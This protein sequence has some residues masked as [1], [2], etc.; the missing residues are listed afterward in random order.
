MYS[1]ERSSLPGQPATDFK[2]SSSLLEQL[3]AYSGSDFYPFHMPGHKRTP[4]PFPNP[5]TVDITEIEGFD[6]LHRPEGILKELQEETAR[7][8]GARQSFLLVNGS[9]CGLLAAVSA[10]VKRGGKLL[11]SRNCHKSVYHAVYLRDLTPVYLLPKLTDFGVMGSLEPEE[12]ER[13]LRAQPDIQAVLAV[14]PTYDGVVSDIERIAAITHRH[15]VPLIVDEAHGA[16]FPFGEE[17]L[18]PTSAL[19]LGADLVVQSLHKTLPAFT[20]TA[21]LHLNTELVEEAVLKRFLGI[22]QS[23]SPSY[24]LM[25]SMAQCMELLKK[26]GPRRFVDF[27]K[28]LSRF[29]QSCRRLS[30]I[31]LFDGHTEAHCFAWDRSKLLIS[32]SELGLSGQ[33]L[34]QILLREY[35]LQMEMASGHYVLALTSLMDREEGFAR[36]AEALFQIERDYGAETAGA[37]RHT[38]PDAAPAPFTPLHSGD[39]YRIPRLAMT[40]ARAMEAPGRTVLL[41]DSA[42]AVSQEYICLYPPGIPLLAPGEVLDEDLLTVILKLKDSGLSLE[43]LSDPTNTR[44]NIVKS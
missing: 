37:L 41:K 23:S 30:H 16:H 28:R 44:I 42:G 34:Y 7:L 3:A 4:F 21:L 33:E 36:L 40:P 26:E 1:D 19:E 31:R 9:T 2:E 13:A 27:G 18:F 17:G 32:A 12:V 24:L 25:A 5:W 38:A 35:H 43:G 29:Y 10:C 8:F 11:L 15:G 22:Y 39:I 20:Q 6:N 14:S